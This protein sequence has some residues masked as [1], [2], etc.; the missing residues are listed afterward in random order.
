MHIRSRRSQERRGLKLNG[1]LVKPGQNG[2]RSQER[3]GL[4]QQEGQPPQQRRR[5]AARKSGV[6]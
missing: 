5:V 3:R 6:D 2:R 1:A 4:K